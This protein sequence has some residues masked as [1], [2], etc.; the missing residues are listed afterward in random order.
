MQQ[1]DTGSAC[2][3]DPANGRTRPMI[4]LGRLI[5]ALVFSHQGHDLEDH[6]PEN[7]AHDRGYD[8]GCQNLLPLAPIDLLRDRLTHQ[9]SIRH[10]NSDDRTDIGMCGGVWDSKPPGSE[11][12]SHRGKDHGHEQR[13]F[14]HGIDAGHHVGGQQ[15]NHAKSDRSPPKEDANEVKDRRHQDGTLRRHGP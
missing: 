12:P 8:Q 13:D 10:R 11:I 3:E 1:T 7:E 5:K 4:I 2:N 14:I 9:E 6:H 15:I